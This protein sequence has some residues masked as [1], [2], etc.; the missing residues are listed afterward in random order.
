MQNKVKSPCHAA[1]CICRAAEH[2]GGVVA[3]PALEVAG[4]ILA[5]LLL[6]THRQA[7]SPWRRS[8]YM[9][10]KGRWPTTWL[11]RE[12]GWVQLFSP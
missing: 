3:I 9:E 1:D 7:L 11:A 8:S 5:T 6:K 4:E 10:V 2:R 12:D